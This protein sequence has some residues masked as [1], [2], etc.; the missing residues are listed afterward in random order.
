MVN[1]KKKSHYQCGYALVHHHLLM[2]DH[3]RPTWK[4]F[5]NCDLHVLKLSVSATITP[6]GLPHHVINSWGIS[7]INLVIIS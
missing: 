5:G 7:P 4:K 3:T 6:G 2:Y 1:W